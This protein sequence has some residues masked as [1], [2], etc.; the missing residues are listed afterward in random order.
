MTDSNAPETASGAE[1]TDAIDR[2]GSGPR[3]LEGRAR[4]RWRGLVAVGWKRTLGKATGG[5]GGRIRFSVAGVA[6]A[7]AILVVVTGV[8]LGLTADATVRGSD[9]DYW[10]VPN[11]GS[12]SALVD[13]GGA[14]LGQVHPTSERIAAI[15]GVEYATPVLTKPIRVRS[16]DGTEEYVLA[17]GVVGTEPN[18]TVAGLSPG[19]LT[20]GDPH[21]AEGTYDGPWTGDLVA[22][23]SAAAVLNVSTGDQ[24]T[25]NGGNRTFRVAAIERSEGG[26]QGEVPIV[27][28]QLSEL[29]ELVGATDSDSADQLLVSTNSRS[30]ADD[31]EAIYPETTVESRTS[32]LASG[33][34]DEQLPLALSVTGLLAA[35]VVGTLFVCT[36]MGMEIVAD[37]R[38]LSTMA[39][40]GLRRRS[41]LVVVAVQTVTVVLLGGVLGV[42]LGALGI[43]VADQ[44]VAFAVGIDGAATF[45]PALLGYGVGIAALIGVLSLPYVL[46]VSSHVA[47]TGGGLR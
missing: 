22:S 13:T 32:L 40:L 9:V 1:G 4:D 7:I 12:G 33:I 43:G 16:G 34:V 38:L 19:G 39:A 15:D 46:V 30:V 27:L 26:P 5:N 29:Q 37:Q 14:S 21:H 41:R 24:L 42:L 44:V 36:T 17:V 35:L 47:R 20:A 45:H 28:V 25:T 11:S 18:P 23:A 10:I 6:I 8:G 31:L 2:R 3:T